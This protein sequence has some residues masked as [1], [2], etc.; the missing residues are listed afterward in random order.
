[1]LHVTGIFATG[2]VMVMI[3]SLIEKFFVSAA[4]QII[5]IWGVEV[6]RRC[7]KSWKYTRSLYRRPG[8]SLHAINS[9]KNIQ[10]KV[11][12]NNEDLLVISNFDDDFK[13]A[14]RSGKSFKY[15]F[16]KIFSV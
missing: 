1:M 4:W 2:N 9:L 8:E 10:I 16:I 11:F 15:L 6:Y 13:K 7:W 12:S 3:L 5:W 14:E